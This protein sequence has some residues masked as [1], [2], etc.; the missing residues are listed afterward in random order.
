[1][2][3]VVNSSLVKFGLFFSLV[4][5]SSLLA[6]PW[7]DVSDIYLR[8]DIQ[9]LADAGVITVPV[10]TYPLMWSGIGVDLAQA[11]PSVLPPALAEAYARVNYY[12]RSAVGNRGNTRIKAAAATDAARFQHFGSDYRE[13]G[14]LQVSHEYMGERFAFK[15][16]ASAH[17]DPVDGEKFRLDD[18]YMAMILGN[19]IFTAGAVEQW[20]GPGFDSALHRSNNARPL[21]SVMVSRNNAAGFETPWLSWLGPWTLTAGISQLEED[22]AVANPLLWN[23]RSSIRP[24]RQLEIGFSWSTQFC[25]EGEECSWES[26]LKS[27]TAQRDCRGAGEGGCSNYGNQMAGYDI[28]FSDS[29]FNIPF[30][31]YYEKTCED[32]KGSAPWDIVDCG[33]FGGIDTRFNFDN[34]Q[35][36][37][38]FEYTDTL[39]ACGEDDNAFNCMY[40]HSAYQSGSRYYGKTYG[41]SYESDATVY[42]LGLIGQFKDS[43]GITSILRYAQL[44]KDGSSP[45]SAW[46]AQRPQ[47]DL[48]MLELSYRMPIWKGMMSVGGT[49]SRSEFDTQESES[50]A[51]LFGTYEYRF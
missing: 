17:Y 25:G 19:W 6:A 23:F 9:A 33:H 45:G 2:I 1:M 51:S 7:V 48:L 4:F 42:A 40:E 24:L 37:L 38:F 8:A 21:P 12:Y 10:N 13:Q 20:W 31:V 16:S 27:I 35:Y 43:K 22:R 32:A 11:E 47:E 5:S 3:K 29:W 39:V 18:A 14:D 49:V 34:A 50:D 26:A 46:V 41:S 44:N 30:G 36:K 28:R 15:V